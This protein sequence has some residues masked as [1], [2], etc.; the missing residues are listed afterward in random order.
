MLPAVAAAR[1]RRNPSTIGNL[2]HAIL[3]ALDA[4]GIDGRAVARAAGISERALDSPNER[5]PQP[6]MTELWH[7]AVAA[8]GDPAFPLD[9]PRHVTV[10]TF[11]ALTYACLASPDLATALRRLVRFQALVSDAV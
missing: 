9:V 10:A 4:R 8:A 2:L 7:R 1:S 5:V 3:R 11:G 6:A